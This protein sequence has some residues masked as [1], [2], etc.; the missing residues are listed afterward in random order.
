MKYM[1]FYELYKAIRISIQ[2]TWKMRA[3]LFE[4]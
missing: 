2:D 3:K 1:K 4:E